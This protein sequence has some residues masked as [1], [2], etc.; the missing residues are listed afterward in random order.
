MATPAQIE[1]QV[2]FEREAIRH[3][4]ERLRKNTKDLEE[5]T[6]ASATVYGC[7]SISTLLPLVTRRIEGTN[8]RIREGKTGRAFKEIHEFLEPIDSSQQQQLR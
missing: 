3:G 6:Y 4:L 2:K 1:A 7:S 8:K 5:K